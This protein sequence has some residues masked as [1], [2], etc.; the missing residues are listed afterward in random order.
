MRQETESWP[1]PNTF[2]LTRTASPIVRLIAKRPPSIS[3]VTCSITTRYVPSGGSSN[4]GCG[5]ARRVPFTVGDIM[6]H[7]T[8]GPPGPERLTLHDVIY[9]RST[10]CAITRWREVQH[11]GAGER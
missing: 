10:R 1:S 3:G 7:D 5:S 6:P 4:F 2:A 9:V 11:E 8:T